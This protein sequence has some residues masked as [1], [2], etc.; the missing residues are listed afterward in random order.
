MYVAKRSS[1]PAERGAAVRGFDPEWEVPVGE[2]E[3]LGRLDAIEMGEPMVGGGT[4]VWSDWLPYRPGTRETYFPFVPGY[5][6]LGVGDFSC[7]NDVEGEVR[8]RLPVYRCDGFVRALMNARKLA[9]EPT[10][11]FEPGNATAN[12]NAAVDCEFVLLPPPGH[13]GRFTMGSRSSEVMS[14][15]IQQQ[16]IQFRHSYLIARTAM[17]QR[18]YL[19]V[20]GRHNKFDWPGDMQPVNEV[21]WND[22][23]GAEG[24]NACAQALGLELRLPSEAEWEFAC[25]GGTQTPYCFGSEDAA[26][27]SE[28]VNF[29]ATSPFKHW[30]MSLPRTVEV[31]SLPMNGFGLFEVHGNVWEWCADV[32]VETLDG[33]PDDGTPRHQAGSGRR[34][35]R[36]GGWVYNSY[37]CPSAGRFFSELDER[38]ADFGFRPAQTVPH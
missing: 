12:A 6:L 32:W 21:S 36:G 37:V 13:N 7:A 17:T 26:M 28:N 9:H 30:S 5:T 31:A 2:D 19:A 29:R 15:R 34:V 16:R 38:I 14:D 33:I 27:M 24:F 11:I 20:G 25:R 10:A 35:Y 8:F 4:R 22:I 18:V 23:T 3:K 1:S